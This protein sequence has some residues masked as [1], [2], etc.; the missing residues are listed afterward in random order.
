VKVHDARDG[1][2][3]LKPEFL[4]G[5]SI[6]WFWIAAAILVMLLLVKYFP[7][8]QKKII[9]ERKKLSQ[10]LDELKSLEQNAA[11]SD[12]PKLFTAQASLVLRRYILDR[13][14][15]SILE[16]T[17]LEAE[18]QLRKSE[19]FSRGT[20]EDVRKVLTQLENISFS[21]LKSETSIQTKAVQLIL[22]CK[23]ILKNLESK[24]PRD[25]P[26]QTHHFS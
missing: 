14:E 1:F 26:G 20:T 19:K 10:Y 3:D 16:S 8:K 24:M 4:Q 5:T 13:T 7:K 9:I 12:S 11:V 22:Q 18:A 2:N 17:P 15:V 23:E 25:T 21:D 6:P